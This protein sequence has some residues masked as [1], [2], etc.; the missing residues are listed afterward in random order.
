M[1]IH[2]LT[3]EKAAIVYLRKTQHYSINQLATFFGRSTSLIHQVIN[4]NQSIGALRLENLRKLPNQTRLKASQTFRF[5]MEFFISR[6]EAFI[7]G[8]TDRPP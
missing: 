1:R 4:F 3:R 6:W 7:L 5:S 8:E 2:W